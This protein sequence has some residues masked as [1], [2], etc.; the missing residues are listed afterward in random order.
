M[1]SEKL[2]EYPTP[3]DWKRVSSAQRERHARF[4]AM[5]P[6][7]RPEEPSRKVE[8][9]PLSGFFDKI[10]MEEIVVGKQLLF[11]IPSLEDV[12][13]LYKHIR[14]RNVKDLLEI[15]Y[16]L[17]SNH[18]N[19]L[20]NVCYWI[21]RGAERLRQADYYLTAGDKWT[22]NSYLDE[23]RRA[24]AIAQETSQAL[25][26]QYFPEHFTQVD[27]DKTNTKTVSDRIVWS[28]NSP[29]ASEIDIEFSSSSAAIRESLKEIAERVQIGCRVERSTP[30]YVAAN[31]TKGVIDDGDSSKV[32]VMFRIKEN[33]EDRDFVTHGVITRTPEDRTTASIDTLPWSDGD[34]ESRLK[35][36]LA[37]FAF[38]KAVRTISSR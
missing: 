38:N 18:R 16:R 30:S 29:K 17:N 21:K 1:T 27:P 5:A 11:K 28:A 35:N 10:N 4:Q 13:T 33:D 24:F 12:E 34:R 31:I 8:S 7:P 37:W 15:D 14:Q 3:E 20:E 23:G 22:G 6:Q 26:E 9:Y 2:P 32:D 36:Q 25:G 19:S